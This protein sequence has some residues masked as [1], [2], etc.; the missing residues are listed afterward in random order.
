MN[1]RDFCYWLKGYFELS[2]SAQLSQDQVD[3]IREHLDLVFDKR[4]QR[5]V[6]VT[7]ETFRTVPTDFVDTELKCHLT[8]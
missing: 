4:T 8:C 3:V 2:H 5:V 7:G 6:T 1:E